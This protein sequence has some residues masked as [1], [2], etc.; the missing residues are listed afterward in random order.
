MR[1]EAGKSTDKPNIVNGHQR[2]GL[3]EKFANYFEVEPRQVPMTGDRFH[4]TGEE[5]VKL[6]DENTI[7]S[8]RSLARPSTA[9]T[10]RWRRLRPRST[11]FRSKPG[12][13]FRSTSTAPRAAWSRRSSTGTGLGLPHPARGQHQHLG[14]QV[15]PGLPGRRL[16]PV[17][18]RDGA[19]RGA[20][21]PRQLPG[22][23]MPTFASTSRAP[24]PR[25]WPSTTCS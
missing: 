25:S 21:L 3:L 18:R 15:R 14:P 8:W 11:A 22:G 6:V 4:L 19:A 5:A 10:S 16:G 17:A 7:A 2:S 13:T 1:K 24:A 9:A 23:D 12:W 20:D